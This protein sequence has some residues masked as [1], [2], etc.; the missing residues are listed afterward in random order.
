MQYVITILIDIFPKYS[1]DFS[2][3]TIFV[4]NYLKQLQIRGLYR[5]T[6]VSYVKRRD[7]RLNDVASTSVC[8]V[9]I[10]TYILI[11]PTPP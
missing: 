2:Y 9:A 10:R 6:G 11:G 3:L 8:L 7:V 5:T 1:H 4:N